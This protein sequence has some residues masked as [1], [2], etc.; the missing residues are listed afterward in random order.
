MVVVMK[1][2]ARQRSC[3]SLLAL[4][5]LWSVV[6]ASGQAVSNADSFR[7]SDL[8]N[9]HSPDVQRAAED[10]ARVRRELSR[11]EAGVSA[12]LTATP[13]A[14]YGNDDLDVE[15][16][17]SEW[18]A[19]VGI[20][21]ALD[22]RHDASNILRLRAEVVRLE[23]NLRTQQRQ[24][25][26]AG[27]LL[28]ID[29]LRQQSSVLIAERNVAQRELELARGQRDHREG[30]ISDND[31]DRMQLTLENELRSLEQ[32]RLRLA[33][34]QT[35]GRDFGMVGELRFEYLSFMLPQV[36]FETLPA[37]QR[38]QLAFERAE[39]D[40]RRRSLYS[41]V[42]D[43]RLGLRYEFNELARA[44]AAIALDRGQPNFNVGVDYRLNDDRDDHKWEV[45][46]SARIRF[47]DR[48][49]GNIQEAERDL[50]RAREELEQLAE[51]FRD[52]VTVLRGD[53]RNSE[54]NVE[55]S[56]LNAHF[57]EVR[58]GELQE[59]QSSIEAA[60]GE[61]LETIALLS[62]NID[63]LGQRIDASE[64]DARRALE[65]QRRT[66]EAERR[67]VEGQ[68]RD[69]DRDLQNVLRDLDR[70]PFD[71]ERA[72]D[73]FFRD[74]S[75]YVRRVGAYLNLVDGRWMIDGDGGD[76]RDVSSELEDSRGATSIDFGPPIR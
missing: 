9:Y 60:R 76:T 51:A 75:D 16:S 39:V 8:L 69:V 55:L 1:T 12:S 24:G 17:E 5:L 28:Y 30:S 6:Y 20:N 37:Y 3:W 40:A 2:C 74:Y 23:E 62:R 35:R 44:S 18:G 66:L 48:T 15:D 59:R 31:L 21:A 22:F 7:P 67:D 13:F 71:L 4:L 36:R 33:E 65:D 10:V 64:G 56:R 58:L 46:L 25:I 68:L 52:D 53:I 70:A 27:F 61:V 34:L 41:V 42:E 26:E 45:R 49:V 11:A 14:R 50:A 72:Q 47:D 32:T 63:V 38:A 54:R 43:V 57:I 19:G 73:T 29:I